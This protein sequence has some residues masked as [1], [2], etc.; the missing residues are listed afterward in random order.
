MSLLRHQQ[1]LMSRSAGGYDAEI[2]V[3]NPAGYWKLDE[4]LG[5]TCLDSSGN[6]RH[7]TNFGAAIGQPSLVT[8]GGTAYSLDG[9]GDFLTM[10]PNFGLGFTSYLFEGWFNFSAIRNQMT[11][12]TKWGRT[13]ADQL[14]LFCWFNATGT[15]NFQA[16]T[17]GA[18]GG[19]KSMNSSQVFSTGQRYYIGLQV[20]GRVPSLP[21]MNIYVN[22]VLNATA[23]VSGTLRVGNTY[24]ALS[25]GAKVVME[26]GPTEADM[27]PSTRY[28]AFKCDNL[29][30][31][32]TYVSPAR[33]AAHYAAGIV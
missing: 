20:D 1:M 3:D 14:T 8:D 11:L 19:V 10:G 29:A 16:Q 27:S 6:A 9:S 18:G 33:I 30:F 23:N 15:I 21:V 28:G 5:T 25:V 7:G 22:G 24:E 32:T 26:P 12:V 17:F 31:Y 2:L 4:T 13:T